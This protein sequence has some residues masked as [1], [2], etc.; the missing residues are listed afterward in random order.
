MERLL[1]EEEEGAGVDGQ[2]DRVL[3]VHV[4]QPEV[5][6]LQHKNMS[7]SGKGFFPN[8]QSTQN[9]LLAILKV[10]RHRINL[11]KDRIFT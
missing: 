1:G 4:V 7:F 5:R 6:R 10:T 2:R 3:E 11:D 9:W 8:R